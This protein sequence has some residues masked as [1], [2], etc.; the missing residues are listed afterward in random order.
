[1]NNDD[2]K[3]DVR[4]DLV[5]PGSDQTNYPPEYTIARVLHKR[6]V[7]DKL[8]QEGECEAVAYR[9]AE[10]MVA[11]KELYTVTL[12]R[13]TEDAASQALPSEN[14]G[15]YE[16]LAGLRM[17]LLHMRD[18]VSE[19]DAHFMDAMAVERAG[20]KTV[21][22]WENPDDWNEEELEEEEP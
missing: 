13:L 11:A 20:D 22:K 5:S 21:P 9:I 3:S 15:L 14:L 10:I 17:A 19:F 7:A 1:M 2:F 12:P 4:P 16:E 8:L 6:F 18:L